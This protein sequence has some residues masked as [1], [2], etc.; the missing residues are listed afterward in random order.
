[1][2]VSRTRFTFGAR[3]RKHTT[4][5]KACTRRGGGFGKTALIIIHRL[6]G[7]NL[8]SY[9]NA[10][11][12]NER[13]RVHGKSPAFERDGAYYAIDAKAVKQKNMAVMGQDAFRVQP[14]GCACNPQPKG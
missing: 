4:N 14:L 12:S 9:C 13:G 8:T 5:K 7:K 11:K 10:C 3:K 1:M 6:T 2:L